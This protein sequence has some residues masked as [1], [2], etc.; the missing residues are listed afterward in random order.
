MN[1]QNRE[2]R[3]R[4]VELSSCDYVVD[5]DLP[6]TPLRQELRNW[7]VV[8]KSEFLDAQSM[9][10]PMRSLYIPG[11]KGYVWGNYLALKNPNKADN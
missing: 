10:Q 2:E 4:Y 6:S 3:Q 9:K 7:T 1:N 8:A 5:V 11:A